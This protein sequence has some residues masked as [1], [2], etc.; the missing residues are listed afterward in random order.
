MCQLIKKKAISFMSVSSS[1]S[2]SGAPILP[3]SVDNPLPFQNLSPPPLSL[4]LNALALAQ[5][6]R[7]NPPISLSKKVFREASKD[8]ETFSLGFLCDLDATDYNG[9]IYSKFEFFLSLKIPVLISR[10]LISQT[11]VNKKEI[12]EKDARVLLA[13]EYTEWDIYLQK[14]NDAYGELIL[15]IPKKYATKLETNEKLKKLGF[16]EKNLELVSYHQV[17]TGP[18]RQACIQDF[19][20]IFRKETKKEPIPQLFLFL[21]G[22]GGQSYIGGLDN[23]HYKYLLNFLQKRKALALAVSSCQAGGPNTLMHLRKKTE[24]KTPKTL[25]FSVFLHSIGDFST[26]SKCLND[27]FKA[28]YFEQLS[29]TLGQNGGTQRVQ[30]QRTLQKIWKGIN[31]IPENLMQIL[32]PHQKDSPAGFRPAEED[33]RGFALTYTTHRRYQLL[34]F[35]KMKSSDP[36]FSWKKPSIPLKVKT[37]TV[38][39]T[40]EFL[41]VFPLCIS[42]PLTTGTVGPAF[43]SMIPG[44][45]HHLLAKI[46]YTSDKHYSSS[47]T[48]TTQF[49]PDSSS[50]SSKAF[51]FGEICIDAKKLFNVVLYFS[52]KRLFRLE[53]KIEKVNE[54]LEEKY[55]YIEQRP[56]LIKTDI[57]ADL[58]AL[59][60][61][62]TVLQ[63]KSSLAAIRSSSGGQESEWDFQ[64]TLLFECFW[65]A[66]NPIPPL[67]NMY[68]Q[69]V[70]RKEDGKEIIS[71]AFKTLIQNATPAEKL[72]LT[73]LAIPA[74]R[75]EL[76]LYLIQ[77]PD[78]DVNG[79]T[80]ERTPLLC[81]CA[82]TKNLA[83]TKALIAKGAKINDQD[84]L[85]RTAL[86]TA[87]FYKNIKMTKYLLKLPGVDTE[88]Q[89]TRFQWRAITYANSPDV[90]TLFVKKGAKLDIESKHGMT[91][92]GLAACHENIPHMDRLLSAGADVNAG[93]HSPLNQSI[94][95][96][97]PL[98]IAH[99][100][101]NNANPNQADGSGDF[102][103]TEAV[104][105]GTPEI[106]RLLIEHGGK[107][108]KETLIAA[109][110]RGCEEILS[111]LEQDID[112][113]NNISI[114][115]EDF[116]LIIE[117]MNLKIAKK[118]LKENRITIQIKDIDDKFKK[119]LPM[120]IDSQDDELLIEFLKFIQQ[121]PAGSKNLAID[122]LSFALTPELIEKHYNA[123]KTYLPALLEN[124]LST[125]LKIA[126]NPHLPFAKKLL[127]NGICIHYKNS[128]VDLIQ[129]VN[130][131]LNSQDNELRSLFLKSIGK[132]V[133][134]NKRLEAMKCIASKL[135]EKN[136]SEL[137]N[138]CLEESPTIAANWLSSTIQTVSTESLTFT[139][140]LLANDVC[141]YYY[142]THIDLRN[143][144]SVV[145]QSKDDELLSLF[146]KGVGKI[147][148]G[149]KKKD[150]LKYLASKLKEK[151]ERELFDKCLD[152]LPDLS[153]DLF[154]EIIRSKCV[155]ID[156]AKKLL[157]NGVCLGHNDG[158]ISI[159][160]KFSSIIT[161]IEE[162][163]DLE[164]LDIFLQ[165]MKN[166]PAEE[167]TAA[168]ERL[169]YYFMQWI[170]RDKK[171]LYERCIYYF[172]NLPQAYLNR[173]YLHSTQL[174]TF[175]LLIQLGANPF[176]KAEAESIADQTVT[177][178]KIDILLLF[179]SKGKPTLEER[180]MLFFK[181][182][183]ERK[184]KSKDAIMNSSPNFKELLFNQIATRLRSGEELH[185]S[186]P[187]LF[188]LCLNHFPPSQEALELLFKN[189]LNPLE[190]NNFL[191]EFNGFKFSIAQKDNILFKFLLSQ[192]NWTNPPFQFND[193]PLDLAMT[194]APIHIERVRL[195]LEHKVTPNRQG[196]PARLPMILAL[197]QNSRPLLDLLFSHGAD[198]NVCDDI[199]GPPLTYA[200]SYSK[201]EE[202]VIYLL[203][204]G[205]N[206]FLKTKYATHIFEEF[207]R[208]KQFAHLCLDLYEKNK[209]KW[210]PTGEKLAQTKLPYSELDLELLKRLLKLGILPSLEAPEALFHAID[211]ADLPLITLFVD[212]LD[213]INNGNHKQ[214]LE[215]AY[216]RALNHN[217][218]EQKIELLTLLQTK[219]N[220]P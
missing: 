200:L 130:I 91:L 141:V 7:I 90:F 119:L 131:V 62:K 32:P 65:N 40:E 196:K 180:I 69:Q 82:V 16:S 149:D 146:L 142:T 74:K 79:L 152:S 17:V 93:K 183:K 191:A 124:W 140:K 19:F 59:E 117:N 205:A 120:I 160:G 4:P 75:T 213:P 30:L 8:V 31:V 171:D 195:A 12:R 58:Y 218:A 5:I 206:P 210:D 137:Y 186:T 39:K 135:N 161:T 26:V 204:K 105:R 110:A 96:R 219:M 42:T 126:P 13:K 51:F 47:I 103:M 25:S 121:L 38:V 101:K 211:K 198:A 133:D 184:V 114:T 63:T 57:S 29:Q 21:S 45:A 34:D 92:L 179:L 9:A 148:D 197:Q 52:D 64:K 187:E 174:E 172:P 167:N 11:D 143:M 162:S 2:S 144:F 77:Q 71:E 199:Y 10:S 23:D 48:K 145:L 86:F 136:E 188:A 175:R 108:N 107:A 46:I 68:L 164:M 80:L 98:M 216:E 72:A 35:F 176:I 53:K 168:L 44:S 70:S 203:E 125:I 6:D 54:I 76:A 109:Y 139:K 27:A 36:I 43:L 115:M 102:P 201:S 169:T 81:L 192:V 73:S 89:D 177:S 100:L 112:W 41:Q 155:H 28:G 189:G 159:Y 128:F 193:S 207:L 1:A 202:L 56:Y 61:W 78:L 212:F 14:N 194:Q 157:A 182:I 185:I 138:I 85:G 87:T 178:E 166:L 118:L 209:E 88:A 33:D 116:F 83:I 50:T 104:K 151:N 99:L 95:R 190:H 214:L 66:D 173:C 220:K 165:K 55:S 18:K 134:D 20:S 129:I 106:L 158:G 150:A 22:H 122:F 215:K 24:I 217:N 37:E 94:A 154:G 67:L 147:V 3:P 97:Q 153:S 170:T 181:A 123:F 163:N 156:L 60:I 208:V 15:L 127:T 111:L 113:I 49:Y 132:I 84:P